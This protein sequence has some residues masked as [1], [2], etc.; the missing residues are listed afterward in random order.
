MI[1]HFEGD[2]QEN[3]VERL[4]LRILLLSLVATHTTNMVCL[5][6]QPHSLPLIRCAQIFLHVLYTLAADASYVPELRAEAQTVLAEHG[7]TKAAMSRM[8][9]MDSYIKEVIRVYGGGRKWAPTAPPPQDRQPDLLYDAESLTRITKVPYTFS[10]GTSIPAGTMVAAAQTATHHDSDIYPHAD[11]FIPSRFVDD[12]RGD[13]AY[14][15]RHSLTTTSNDYCVSPSPSHQTCPL[16]DFLV[17][18]SGIWTWKIRCDMLCL[19]HHGDVADHESHS[20]S[21]SILCWQCPQ[22]DAGSHDPQL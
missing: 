13:D 9:K 3:L 18:D 8:Y 1:I 21:G 19:G 15:V 5:I 14:Q 2:D 22:G 20:L 11:E 10:D 6:R 12:F 4:V 17:L 7:P 16:A